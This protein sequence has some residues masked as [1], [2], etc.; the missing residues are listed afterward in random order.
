MNTK[1]PTP[2]TTF[3]AQDIGRS[4][5]CIMDGVMY[6][7]FQ[8]FLH[9]AEVYFLL[10]IRSGSGFIHRQN[11]TLPLFTGTILFADC[12]TASTLEV[13]GTPFTASG[14]LLTSAEAD[15]AY[16]SYSSDKNPIF[17]INGSSEIPELISRLIK[18]CTETSEVGRALYAEVAGDLFSYLSHCKSADYGNRAL[19]PLYILSMKQLLDTRYAEAITLDTI[20]SDLHINK[21]KLAKEFKTF[22]FVSPIEYLIRRRIEVA[23]G[24]L[25][26]TQKTITQIGSD[27]AM[28]N[29]PY[30][31]RLFKQRKGISPL[32]YRTKNRSVIE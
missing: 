13:T 23:C 2:P 15:N 32:K 10:Y 11:S 4:V 18:L 31:V 19:P 8:L 5:E 30:F 12:K 17:E 16:T 21:Y 22:Y 7:P 25:L 29:T 1:P 3:M 14:F 27:I 20:S 6:S 28:E 24:L 26:D 9:Q